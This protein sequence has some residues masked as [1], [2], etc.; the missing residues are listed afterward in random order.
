MTSGTF[1]GNNFQSGTAV[2]PGIGHGW[3]EGNSFVTNFTG[4]QYHTVS[5]A[6]TSL[7][8]DFSDGTTADVTID[9]FTVGLN[10][11]YAANWALFQSQLFSGNDRMIGSF[12]ADKFAGGSGADVLFGGYGDKLIPFNPNDPD[13]NP[14]SFSP[15]F[16]V[17][18]GFFTDDGADILNGGIGKDSLDGGT[19]SDR[20]YGGTQG[21]LLFGGGTGNDSL[22]G[23]A[24]GDRLF[25]GRGIDM[26]SG[27][28]GNDTLTGNA[29]ADQFVLAKGWG[30]DTITDFSANNAEDIVLNIGAAGFGDLMLH[31]LQVDAGT[32]FARIVYGTNSILLDGFHVSDFGGAGPIT[33]ADFQFH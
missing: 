7:S 6:V 25:G 3:Y 12:H 23:G 9:Q 16:M 1:D 28:G 19:N 10:T 14:S 22:F 30:S 11:L 15:G 2:S 27:D 24:D 18:P 8:V 4:G 26:L 20:L 29:D 5:G 17:A 13:P 21:D 31:H 32:G 33:A